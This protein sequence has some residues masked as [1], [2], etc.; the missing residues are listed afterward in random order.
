MSTTTGLS[1]FCYPLVTY[2]ATLRWLG[3]FGVVLSLSGSCFGQTPLVTLNASRPEV[4]V[5]AGEFLPDPGKVFSIQDFVDS[6]STAEFRSFSPENPGY[7]DTIK[8]YW[9]RF[10]VFNEEAI[11]R[12]WIFNFDGWSHVVLYTVRTDGPVSSQQ[13]GHLLPIS[14]RDYPVAN[15]NNILVLLP[16]NT[17]RTYYVSLESK[18][19]HVIRP[20]G[21]SF[22]GA[23]RAVQDRKESRHRQYIGIFL[24]IYAVM[25]LYNFFIYTSTRDRA[26]VFFLMHIVGLTYM[27]LNNSGHSVSL[28]GAFFENFPLWRGSIES[29]VSAYNTVVAILFTMTFLNTK[30]YLPFWHKVF[31]GIL[32]A[33]AIC[34]IG[35]NVKFDLFAPFIYLLMILIL[36]TFV[37]VAIKSIRQ[38]VPSAKY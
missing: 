7:V 17:K 28:F 34:A 15:K 1:L 2:R 3:A 4:T 27:T 35:A 24:G 26:Y 14:Q 9:L 12:E 33:I 32:I 30:H 25:F 22:K 16:R 36:V 29:L 8:N 5:T 10:T 13:T 11:D 21:L 23:V 20:S 6:S 38:P 31:R 19:D 37:T 18:P